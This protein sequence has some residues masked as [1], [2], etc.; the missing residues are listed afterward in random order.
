MYDT[1]IG[2]LNEFSLHPPHPPL[3]LLPLLFG[4]HGRLRHSLGGRLTEHVSGTKRGA[5]PT[6]HAGM[7]YLP[8]SPPCPTE[9]HSYFLVFPE[10]PNN[11]SRV[12]GWR[13]RRELLASASIQAKPVLHRL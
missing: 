1:N 4:T 9:M 13:L 6:R 10:S 12:D 7:R 5:S 8:S 11:R 3:Q 2:R